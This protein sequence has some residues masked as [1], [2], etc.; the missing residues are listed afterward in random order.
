MPL[1][2]FFFFFSILPRD[3]YDYLR[4]SRMHTWVYMEKSS[5]C[6]IFCTAFTR[7]RT[8]EKKSDMSI[9]SILHYCSDSY[10]KKEFICP[11]PPPIL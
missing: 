1:G 2:P 11:P 6:F 8:F 3:L 7:R 9:L 5:V 4:G 10:N